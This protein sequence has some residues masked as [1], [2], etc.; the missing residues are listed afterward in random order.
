MRSELHEPGSGFLPRKKRD[1]VPMPLEP[2]AVDAALSDETTPVAT[3]STARREM[4]A[5]SAAAEAMRLTIDHS[6][7][8]GGSG[9]TAD[10]DL[11]RLLSRQLSSLEAQQA[12]IRQLLEQ[13]ERRHGAAADAR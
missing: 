4:R 8:A 9:E 13:T 5:T 12:Q 3:P 7:A 10:G 11:L 2:S 6:H 1:P